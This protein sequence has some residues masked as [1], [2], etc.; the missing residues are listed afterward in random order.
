MKTLG[1][2][3]AIG[4]GIVAAGQ[5]SVLDISTTSLPGGMTMLP[6][7]ATLTATGGVTPYVWSIVT[8]YTEQSSS[9]SF[10]LSGTA[11]GW[12]ADD[13]SW[14]MSLPFSFPFYGNTYTSLYVSSNGTITFDGSHTDWNESVDGLKSRKMIAALWDDLSTLSPDDIYVTTEPDLVTIRWAG[15]YLSSA[16]AVSFSV[17]LGANGTVFLRYGTG[18]TRGGLIGISAGDTTNHVISARSQSG[19][20][21]NANDIV[22]RSSDVLPPGLILTPSGVVTGKPTSAVT[23]QPLFTVRDATNASAGRAIPIAIVP[24]PDR[25]PVVFSNQPPAG[26]VTMAES[27]SRVFAVWA[28]DPDGSNVTYRWTRDGIPVGGSGNQYTLSAAWGDAGQQTLRCYVSD[29]LWVDG[30]SVEWLV[31]VVSDNDGDGIPNAYELCY[32]GVLSPWNPADAG[33]DPDGDHA[34]SLVEFQQG[35]IPTDPDSDDDSLPDG[36]EI[37]YHSNPNSPTGALRNVICT[38]VGKAVAALGCGEHQDIAITGQYAFVAA[39]DGGLQV[40]DC[41]NPTNPVLVGFCETSG[42]ANDVALAGNYAYVADGEAGLKIVNVSDRAHPILVGGYDTPDEAQSVCVDGSYAYVADRMSGLH[43]LDISNPSNPVLAG[44]YDTP[45]WCMSVAVRGNNAYVADDWT[46]LV[47]LDVTDKASPSFVGSY[48]TQDAFSIALSGDY[49]FIADGIGGLKV[50][51]VRLPTAPVLAGT[52]P[53]TGDASDVFLRDGKAYVAT[54][55][56][57]LHVVSIG[58]P[59]APS[60]VTTFDTDGYAGGVAADGTRVFVADG[61]LGLTVLRETPGV[62][63]QYKGK[64][65]SMDDGPCAVDATGDYVLMADGA[66]GLQVID[67]FD[68][69][70]PVMVG[71]VDTPDYAR[72]VVSG[73]GYAYVVDGASGLQVISINNPSNPAVVGSVDTPGRAQDVVVDGGFAFVADDSSGLRVVDVSNPQNPVSVGFYD[74]PFCAHGVSVAEGYAYVADGLSLMVFD[75]HVPSN[76]V[77]IGSISPS[78]DILDVCVTGGFAYVACGWDGLKVI[79]VQNPSNPVQV[80]A[81]DT[82]DHATDIH[83]SGSYVVVS[84]WVGNPGLWMFDISNPSKPLPAAAL[85]TPGGVLGAALKGNRLYV[86]DCG[87][88]LLVLETIVPGACI[89]KEGGAE[90]AMARGVTRDGDVAWVAAG[91]HGVIAVNVADPAVP[92]RLGMIDTDGDAERVRILGSQAYV[93]DGDAGMQVLDVSN[94]AAPAQI[95]GF[96]TAYAVR[97][98]SVSGDSVYL[99]FDAWYSSFEVLS[100][101][102]PSNPVSICSYHGTGIEGSEALAGFL[103]AAAGAGGLCIFNTADPSDPTQIGSVDTPGYARDVS[104]WNGHAYVADDY[105]GLRVI[106]VSNPSNPVPVGA[107]AMNGDAA[108]SVHATGDYAYV[109]HSFSG[110]AVYDVAQPTNPTVAGLCEAVAP[111]DEVFARGN[112]VLVAARDRGLQIVCVSSTDTDGD[113]LPDRWET[114][115]FTNLQQNANIDFDGDGISNKGEA[116]ADLNPLD[117][118]QDRD[119]LRDGLETAVHHS[120]PD[121]WDTD[122]DGLSD[123]EEVTEGEDGFVTRADLADTD[124]DG[125]NDGQEVDLLR[126]PNDPGDGGRPSCV[127]GTVT[128]GGIGIPDAYVRFEGPT[129]GVVYHTTATDRE[130][131]YLI[132]GITPGTY[133]VKVGAEGF[134]DEWYEDASHRAGADGFVVPSNSLLAGVNFDLAPGHSPALAEVTSYPTGAVVYIDHHPTEFMTPATVDLGEADTGIA[135]AASHSVTV[136]KPGHSWPE[137]ERVHAVEGETVSIHFDLTNQPLGTLVIT[138]AVPGVS[139][140]V[141]YMDAPAGTTPIV[142]TNLQEA[143]SHGHLVVARKPGYLLPRPVWV[144]VESGTVHTLDI[145]MTSSAMATG[146]SVQVLSTPPGAEILVDYVST[147]Q[148]TDDTVTNLDDSLPAWW[149]HWWAQGASHTVQVRKGG[150]VRPLPRYVQAG[151]DAVWFHLRADPLQTHDVNHNGLPDEWENSYDWTGVPP[152]E[153][154]AAG[155]ADGDGRTNEDEMRA[156]TD[157]TRAASRFGLGEATAPRPDGFPLHIATVPGRRYIVQQT[158]A[159]TEPWQTISGVI[160]ATDFVTVV[161]VQAAPTDEK[162][163]YRVVVLP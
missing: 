156:G 39:G 20:M 80:G 70:N 51:D 114:R 110:L 25:P 148:A 125:T 122:D 15:H 77:P 41:A 129:R 94:P 1:I 74:T 123:F 75:V 120:R 143:S 47:V 100:V 109:A 144:G 69:T 53:L 38:P 89:L 11:R 149:G 121:R 44:S 145:P 115:W 43:I 33:A 160:E 88:G 118:D 62:G 40:F 101:S 137:I 48:D 63:L 6:Y 99:S 58:L 13:G 132:T 95:G 79:N 119:G 86:A 57:G 8:G 10:S 133:F 31:T 14:Q 97:D 56:S 108:V 107:G 22:F 26:V 45:D 64:R 54:H 19:S 161:Y 134:A 128:G 2:A 85:D 27:T 83:V 142:L 96:P 3:L 87:N 72:A 16:D 59:T 116:D 111:A 21:N 23:N 106:A 76:P 113:G 139:V 18:N 7:T 34:S 154:G 17:A 9:S 66:A 102:D 150:Y 146:S 91:T 104:L 138:S 73:G 32:P 131:G 12:H 5:A 52:C 112:T 158:V 163:F 141:D 151:G 126:N 81:Y 135:R 67:A 78:V 84:D 92:Q 42:Y 147:A 155:D 49:A 124:G 82:Y 90:P 29:P 93:A 30:A 127:G 140:Y 61:Y 159:L 35:T 136:R 55:Y 37:T 36:W 24:N 46:G 28:Q 60:L 65:A 71:W 4:A 105:G 117:P 130:G 162:A 153:R 152:G 98:L 68:P 157:P 103:Y 50:I